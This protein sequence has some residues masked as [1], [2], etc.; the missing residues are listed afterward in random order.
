ML[1]DGSTTI[2][3]NG[4][5]RHQQFGQMSSAINGNNVSHNQSIYANTV[6]L[7]KMNGNVTTGKNC[8]TIWFSMLKTK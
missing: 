1:E 5:L 6:A 2:R 4:G 7:P 8:F 3:Q